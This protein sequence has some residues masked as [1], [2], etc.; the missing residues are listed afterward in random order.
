MAEQKDKSTTTEPVERD[1]YT[2]PREREDEGHEDAGQAY[3]RE[4][5]EKADEDE[6]PAK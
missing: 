2:K 6:T 1:R 5:R 4:Q 3:V